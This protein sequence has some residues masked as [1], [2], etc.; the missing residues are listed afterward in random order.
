MRIWETDS[1]QQVGDPLTGHRGAAAAVSIDSAGRHVASAGSDDD[2]RLW[3]IESHQAFGERLTGHTEQL[4]GLDFSPDGRRLASASF[5][6]T[7]RLWPATASPE[8]LCAK[9]TSNMSQRQWNDWVSPE[10]DYVTTCPDLPV[11]PD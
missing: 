11:T 6:G 10:I 5:D 9:L 3:D 4:L 1:H 2:I 7:V 8:D